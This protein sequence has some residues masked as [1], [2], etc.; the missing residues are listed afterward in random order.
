MCKPDAVQR[1]LVG[2]IIGRFE[3]RGYKLV[4]M[5]LMSVSKEL[6]ESHYC[7]LADKPFFPDL[8]KFITSSPVVAMVWEGLDIVRQGRALIGAT[9]PRKSAPGSVRGDLAVCLDKNILHGSDSCESAKREIMM[10]FKPD[11]VCSY[12]GCAEAWIY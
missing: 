10:W 5:K 11:E 4:A 8:V 12:V 3:K 2:E 9:D 1:R 6:A 7:D